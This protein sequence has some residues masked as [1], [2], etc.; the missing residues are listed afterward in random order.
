MNADK[1]LSSR[2]F[3]SVQDTVSRPPPSRWVIATDGYATLATESS[4]ATAGWG[5]VVH[6]I[7]G[8]RGF[9]M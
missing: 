8:A 7:G 1:L 9:G 4:P 6:R 3:G 5:F 2:V